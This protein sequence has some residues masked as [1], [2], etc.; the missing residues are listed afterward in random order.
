MVNRHIARISSRGTGGATVSQATRA[1]D[2]G[3]GAGLLTPVLAPHVQLI[4]PQ[5]AEAGDLAKIVQ[6]QHPPGGEDHQ[7]HIGK[8]L[9]AVGQVENGSPRCDWL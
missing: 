1:L 5:P 4:E 7:P 2:A 8:D 9:V 3:C 6:L